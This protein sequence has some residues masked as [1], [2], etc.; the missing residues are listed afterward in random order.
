L[1]SSNKK[2][3]R[4]SREEVLG[5][6]IR[7]ASEGTIKTRIMYKAALNSRQLKR[8]LQLLIKQGLVQ[9]DENDKTY[10]STEKGKVYLRRLEDF[11]KA[12]HQLLDQSRA[13]KEFFKSEK[14][15]TL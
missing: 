4:R 15:S 9:F 5:E 6:I 12:K 7:A 14:E 2:T 8:Y 13:L 10:L 3:R 11:L 1:E